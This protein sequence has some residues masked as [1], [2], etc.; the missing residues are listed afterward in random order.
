MSFWNLFNSKN[1]CEIYIPVDTSIVKTI[2]LNGHKYNTGTSDLIAKK[3]YKGHY[4]VG[5]VVYYD[6]EEHL[7]KTNKDN[8]F[9]LEYH[10]NSLH[11]W[12]KELTKGEA[13]E[14]YY[15]CSEKILNEIEAFGVIE[16]Q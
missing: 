5:D 16:E 6:V 10:N 3:K 11:S 4:F 12:S 13:L 8:Y 14:L 7:Y 15:K 9:V 1:K 2:I